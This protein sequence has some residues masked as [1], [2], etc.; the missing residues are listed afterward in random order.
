MNTVDELME[1]YTRALAND[2]TEATPADIDAIIAYQRAY[3]EGHLSGPKKEKVVSAEPKKKL[4]LK[5]L[6]FNTAP[7]QDLVI[8]RRL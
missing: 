3:R 1:R 6:G 8:T 2:P 4:D 5:S 7:K